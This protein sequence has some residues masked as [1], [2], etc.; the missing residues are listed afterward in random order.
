MKAKGTASAGETVQEA[1]SQNPELMTGGRGL[2]QGIGN[3]TSVGGIGT[4]L[5]QLVC[6]KS[7]QSHCAQVYPQFGREKNGRSLRFLKGKSI[8]S[9]EVSKL[10]DKLLA[11]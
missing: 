4:E 6:F 1:T 8:L 7:S 9:S 10:H 11:R 2:I 3:R 5:G